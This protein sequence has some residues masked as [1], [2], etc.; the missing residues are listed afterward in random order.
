MHA[1]NKNDTWGLQRWPKRGGEKK[2]AGDEGGGEIRVKRRSKGVD[3]ESGSLRA[4]RD[5]S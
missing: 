4:T 1:A 3:S 2:G 5:L